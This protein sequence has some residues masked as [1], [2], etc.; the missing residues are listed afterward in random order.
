MKE[1]IQNF[2]KGEKRRVSDKTR[3]FDNERRR[4]VYKMKSVKD[5]TEKMTLVAR[6]KAI[7]KEG[8]AF[9]YG[10]ELDENY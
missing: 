1:Y 2:D 5:E 10:D 9:L 6:L 8:V 4:I 7:E 3:Y